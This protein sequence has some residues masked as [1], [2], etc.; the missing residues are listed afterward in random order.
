MNSFDTQGYHLLNQFAG[1]HAL[2]DTM[3]AFIAQYSLELYIVL[4]IV[5]WFA[6]PKSEI[7]QR[8]SLVIMGFA[9][10]FG[11][12]INVLVSHIYFRPRPFTVLARGTFTQLIPHSPDASFPSDHTTGSFGFA[13][14]SWGKTPKWFSIG[15]TFLGLFNAIARLYVGV[16]WPTDVIAGIVIGTICGRLLW[17]FNGLFQPLTNFGL[18][19]FHYGNYKQKPLSA[20]KIIK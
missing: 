6:L 19:L 8:H 18:R 3:M 11:L 4:F 2:I 10:V 13:A 14:A 9:G 15:F 17:R 12:I 20:L 7:K 16:H 1:H 5:A